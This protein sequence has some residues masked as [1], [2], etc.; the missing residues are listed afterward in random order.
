M[1]KHVARAVGLAVTVSLAAGCGSGASGR[2]DG[3]PSDAMVQSIHD[4]LPAEI[5]DAGAMQVVISGLNPP[6][7]T[8]TPG[9]QGARTGAGAELMDAVGDVMGVDVQIVA[10]P[11]VSGAFAAIS[12]ERYAFGFFPYADSVGGPRERPGAEFVD[13]VQ[14]VVPF[15]VR[16]GNPAGVTS[17]AGLCDVTVAALVN[18]ATYQAAEDQ[19]RACREQGAG[20]DVLGVTSV[21]DGVL[22]VRSGRADTFF[23]GGASL[24]HAAEESGGTLEVVGADADNGFDGQFMGALLPKGSPLT[25]PLLD[26]F[27]VLFDN[28]TYR[29]ILGEYG[30]D[31]EMIE[32]PGVDLHAEWLAGRAGR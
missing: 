17:M 29:Q 14:E 8:T 6:W 19:A 1:S 3:R 10:V 24:F 12:T 28:G 15:L 30:L 31:R 32:K 7:W 23:S 4:A 13:V 25:R 11:D 5:R 9:K 21:P 2:P 22:A 16:A 20:L 26:A 27:Q 18:A